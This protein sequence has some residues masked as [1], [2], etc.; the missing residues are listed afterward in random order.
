MEAEFGPWRLSKNR[1]TSYTNQKLL[2][3]NQNTASCTVDKC[4]ALLHDFLPYIV[5]T[6][7]PPTEIKLIV[8]DSVTAFKWIVAIARVCWRSGPTAG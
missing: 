1:I 3:L 7:F 2:I 6:T 8:F 5:V 4:N